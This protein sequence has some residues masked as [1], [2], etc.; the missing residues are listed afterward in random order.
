[1]QTNDKFPTL[2]AHRYGGQNCQRE[3]RQDQLSWPQ[4]LKWEFLTTDWKLWPFRTT[5]SPY[6]LSRMY[7]LKMRVN[8]SVVYLLSQ[9]LWLDSP[10]Y[11]SR[12]SVMHHLNPIFQITS[13]VYLVNCFP[14]SI[15]YKGNE[16]IFTACLE[17]LRF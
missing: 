12:V 13:Y 6:S 16:L 15:H 9:E 1:M 8:T 5:P 7:C 14:Y 2:S 11:R 3:V 4:A 10:L 17:D